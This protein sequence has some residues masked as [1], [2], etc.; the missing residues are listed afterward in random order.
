MKTLS[1][2]SKT[3]CRIMILLTL[4][5]FS[6]AQTIVFAQSASGEVAY[7]A[8]NKPVNLTVSN[9]QYLT[10]PDE[11]EASKTIRRLLF[12]SSDITTKVKS[13]QTLKCLDAEFIGLQVDITDGPRLLYWLVLNNQMVQYSGTAQ[14]KALT[15]TENSP[16][17]VAGNLAIDDSKAGGPK[18]N[19]KFDLKLN[20]AFEK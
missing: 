13:C 5:R 8:K 11:M 19:I 15:L 14:P 7:V 10:G 18:I 20:R 17:H 6:C 16:G 3:I 2:D 4:L 9:G 1:H 12:T